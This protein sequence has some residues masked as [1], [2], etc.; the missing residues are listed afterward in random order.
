MLPLFLLFPNMQ[1]TT[2]WNSAILG[3]LQDADVVAQFE[4]ALATEW[5]PDMVVA[6]LL[7]RGT[8]HRMT[9]REFH[10]RC[11]RKGPTLTLIRFCPPGGNGDVTVCGGVA[12][13]S[14]SSPPVCS[15]V[16]C[17]RAF[18]FILVSP[19]VRIARF[20]V[21]CKG[22]MALRCSEELISFGGNL[23]LRTG[24]DG[25]LAGHCDFGWYRNFGGGKLENHMFTG[26]PHRRDFWFSVAEVE[27]FSIQRRV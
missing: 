27:V 17:P 22:V 16:A 13:E 18:V 7:F 6:D 25:R 12:F 9:A 15:F 20:P 2:P 1:A 5:L 24:P 26:G 8:S 23:S 11:N 4:A 21:D 14:W 10:V 19:A 3:G